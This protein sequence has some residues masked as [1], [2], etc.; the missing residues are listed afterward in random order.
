MNKGAKIGLLALGSVILAA[1]AMAN[2]VLGAATTIVKCSGVISSSDPVIHSQSCT[3]MYDESV[4]ADLTV[5][6]ASAAGTSPVDGTRRDVEGLGAEIDF[7]GGGF[8]NVKYNFGVVAPEDFDPLLKVP[9]IV[10][11]L[12]TS[13]IT[14]TDGD[15]LVRTFGEATLGISTG[16][17]GDLGL[18]VCSGDCTQRPGDGVSTLDG[19]RTI[20]LFAD[21]TNNVTLSAQIELSSL[22]KSSASALV[23]PFFQIDPAFL[24]THPGYSIVVSD[25][26]PNNPP[27]GSSTV[28]EPSTV[29]PL[30]FGMLALV[31]IARKNVNRR[32]I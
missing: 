7:P 14:S 10:S 21:T 8:A 23:D 15:F 12:L 32:R 19:S 1:P 16:Q 25:G 20:D 26:V 31:G 28:P 27:E 13:G 30:G 24:S 11:A 6:S 4:T 18:A 5:A 17:I 2:I 22:F 29:W 3:G 9:V